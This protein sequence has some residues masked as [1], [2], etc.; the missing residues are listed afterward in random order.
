MVRV[1]LKIARLNNWPTSEEKMKTK[2]KIKKK[3]KEIEADERIK[4]PAATVSE[5]APL[6]LI[7][8]NLE[9]TRGALKWVL[10]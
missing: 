6:A 1:R 7:Q 8:T 2:D 4:Y 3:L 9:A 5:N 10:N